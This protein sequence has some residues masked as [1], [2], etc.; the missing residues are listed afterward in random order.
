MTKLKTILV[1]GGSRGIGRAIV[2]ELNATHRVINLSRSET[3]VHP[4][5][6][7]HTL[8]VTSDQLPVYESI[9]KLVYCP[10]SINL[11][12]FNRLELDEFQSDLN[13]NLISAIRVIKQYIDSLRATKGSVVLFSTVATQV[14]MPFHA[15]VATSKA[16][17]EGL[18]KS[19]AAEYAS[20]VRFNCIAPTITDTPLAERL[21]RTDKQRESMQS[22]HPLG[23]ILNP[24]EVAKMAAFLLS[25][26]ASSISGQVLLMDSGLANLK[27]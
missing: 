4:N 16:A 7:N 14:G 1:V 6:V 12:P 20:S 19:L 15:S 18:C 24:Q 10:G 17:L 5:V 26:N 27:V 9:D 11:K 8:D 23:R 3:I 25:D 13:I 2:E 22:R 21:L